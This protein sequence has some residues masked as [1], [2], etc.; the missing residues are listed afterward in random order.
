[1]KPEE[2]TTRKR[3]KQEVTDTSWETFSFKPQETNTW[4][5]EVHTHSID[6]DSEWSQIYFWLESIKSNSSLGSSIAFPR[7]P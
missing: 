3:G 2:V 5:I 1:M 4:N 7:F 6:P